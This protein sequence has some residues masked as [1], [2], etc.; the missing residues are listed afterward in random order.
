[1]SYFAFYISVTL[2][3]FL[4]RSLT[5]L[6][7][8]QHKNG[9]KRAHDNSV[10]CKFDPKAYS[11]PQ[12]YLLTSCVCVCVL[13]WHTKVDA[14]H[15]YGDNLERQLLLR[16]HKDGKLKYQVKN[17]GFDNCFSTKTYLML[18]KTD[19]TVLSLSCTVFFPTDSERWD[20]PSHCRGC[21]H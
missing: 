2:I 12:S 3:V 13:S 17:Q 15:I 11:P 1:M 6:N 16:L 20:L 14:G 18:I 19:I 21:S 7:Q 5:Y 4:H 8:S 9:E 10:W